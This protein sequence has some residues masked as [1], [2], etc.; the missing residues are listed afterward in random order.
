MNSQ[1]IFSNRL[2]VFLITILLLLSAQIS[3][4]EDNEQPHDC[5][6]QAVK[7]II[8]IRSLPDMKYLH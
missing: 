8:E 2:I 6:D 5:L 7:R 3:L 4:S 1:R